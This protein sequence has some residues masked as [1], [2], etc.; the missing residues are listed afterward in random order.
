MFTT[1]SS[2]RRT[3]RAGHRR[4]GG[5]RARQLDEVGVGE[6][7]KTMAQERAESVLRGELKGEATPG[8]EPGTPP[9]GGI[10]ARTLNFGSRRRLR[11]L[12]R[13]GASA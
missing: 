7:F 4:R 10:I 8:L 6:P 2:P 3:R 1:A 11:T 12:I 9:L 5:S 13:C